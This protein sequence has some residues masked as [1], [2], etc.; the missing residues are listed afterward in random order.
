MSCHGRWTRLTSFIHHDISSVVQKH[1]SRMTT[2]PPMSGKPKDESV[3]DPKTDPKL[4]TVPSVYRGSRQRTEVFR[5][6]FRRHDSLQPTSFIC[7]EDRTIIIPFQHF[8]KNLKSIKKIKQITP[9]MK[10]IN[11]VIY[12]LHSTCLLTK[13]ATKQN[14]TTG[15]VDQIS[16]SPMRYGHVTN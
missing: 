5:R 13:N 15:S 2:R 9:G 6:Y 12:E 1:P 3:T 10:H 4:K 16:S 8:P 7:V 14:K 11:F